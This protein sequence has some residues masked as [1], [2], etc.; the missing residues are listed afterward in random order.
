MSKRV[1][2]TNVPKQPQEPE[3]WCFECKDGG[4]VVVCDHGNCGKV[5]HPHCIDQDE[6]LSEVKTWV[7]GWHYCITCRDL[8]KYYCLGCANGSLCDKCIDDSKLTVIK[9]RKG[10]CSVCSE[11]VLIIEQKLEQDSEGNKLSM[12]D[13][14]TYECLFKEYWEIVKGKEKL[15]GSDVLAALDNSKKDKSFLFE[16]DSSEDEKEK[17]EL[18]SSDSDKGR[19]YKRKTI[20]RKKSKGKE[21]KPSSS[22]GRSVL[23][24]GHFCVKPRYHASVNA[25]NI[26]LIYL[27]ESLVQEL[28][29]EP[30]S[31]TNK[32]VGAFVRVKMDPKDTKQ[33]NSHQLVKVIGVLNDETSNGILFQVSNRANAIPI[34]KISNNDFTAEEV[35]EKAILLHED[36]TKHV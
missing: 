16:S 35:Q 13:R 3:D 12:N 23:K 9:R 2:K 36:V 11:L 24:K 25:K 28:S 34:S 33:K 22:R 26:N 27:K 30:E 17:E 8:A 29:K 5:Y 20:R 21:R 7:C 19:T 14:E 31:F 4:N 1:K 15:T 10:L 32:V 18:I 6:S